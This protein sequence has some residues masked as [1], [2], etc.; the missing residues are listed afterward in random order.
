MKTL[1]AFISA[2]LYAEAF[3]SIPCAEDLGFQQ[4]NGGRV[5][6]E[7]TERI[8]TINNKVGLQKINV[9]SLKDASID[10]GN[11]SQTAT[12]KDVVNTGGSMTINHVDGDEGRA[13]GVSVV[14]SFTV[15]HTI[16]KWGLMRVNTVSA[17]GLWV[18]SVVQ[19]FRTRKLENK[20]GYVGINNFGY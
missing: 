11:I 1:H 2:V 5:N 3:A 15:Q 17:Q 20:F 19:I 7:Q 16:N 18:P 10:S 4:D 14:Q 13:D 9:V 8:K 6:V 12:G